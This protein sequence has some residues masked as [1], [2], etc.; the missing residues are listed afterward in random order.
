MPESDAVQMINN[1]FQNKMYRNSS[2]GYIFGHKLDELYYSHEVIRELDTDKN[3]GF[4]EL[5][6]NNGN[7]QHETLKAVI[8][9]NC[10]VQW[11][12]G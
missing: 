3:L 9:S 7:S 4:I 1:I 10:E 2:R 12:N 5:Q 8:Y 6:F 11:I